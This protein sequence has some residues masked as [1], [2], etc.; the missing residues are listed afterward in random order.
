MSATTHNHII[1]QVRKARSV[2]DLTTI[3]S[4]IA[5]TVKSCSQIT[6]NL[7]R[8]ASRLT[9]SMTNIAVAAEKDPDEIDIRSRGGRVN[10][11]K[12]GGKVAPVSSVLTSFKPPK[13]GNV[14]QHTDV[15]NNL[16][17]KSLELDSVEALLVQAFVGSKGQPAAL[18]AVRALKAEIDATLQK[19]FSSLNQVADTHIPKEFK[20]LG[21]SVVSYL[22]TSLDK[23]SYA[24]ITHSC[25]VFRTKEGLWHYTFYVTIE[26]LKNESGFTFDDYN[27]VLSA[28][29]DKDKNAKY[30]LTTLADFRIPG[31]FPLGKA[32]TSANDIKT[33]LGIMLRHND[34]INVLDKKHMPL[35]TDGARKHGLDNLPGVKDA[36][37]EDDTLILKLMKRTPPT[38][39]K[40]I[41]TKVLPLLNLMVGNKTKKSVI[42]HKQIP[43]GS[44][45]E[46]Q[47]I[48]VP[49]LKDAET[50]MTLEK[51]RDLQHALDLSADEVAAIKSALKQPH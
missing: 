45:K 41:L 1:E 28:M 36:I 39:V 3:T 13:L 25:Y 46:L 5:R 7:R 10:L 16:Y 19:A 48:L 47:F 38:E 33:V 40:A 12:L 34:V 50:G 26:G 22:I 29:I 18:K 15:I 4:N 30:Y 43:E 2:Q 9:I 20:D 27:V 8:S 32:V 23:K 31:K 24:N 21:D 42:T 14:T 11:G 44:P 37:V 51:L 6:K 35:S 17:D 49:A